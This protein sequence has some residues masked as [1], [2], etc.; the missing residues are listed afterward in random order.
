MVTG[1]KQTSLFLISSA[2]AHIQSHARTHT[3]FGSIHSVQFKS[4]TYLLSLTSDLFYVVYENNDN[5]NN[6]IQEFSLPVVIKII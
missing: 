1:D 3:R 2:L 5:N 4:I 6:K